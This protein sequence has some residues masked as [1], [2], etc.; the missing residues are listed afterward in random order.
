[1]ESVDGLESDPNEIANVHPAAV[2]LRFDGREQLLGV[3][4][5]QE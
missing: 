2:Q 4:V 1:M 5:V 3:I